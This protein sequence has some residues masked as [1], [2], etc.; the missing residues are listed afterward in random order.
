MIKIG[1]LGASDPNAGELLRILVNH[2]DVSIDSLYEPR[3]AGVPVTT[4]HHGLIA[5]LDDT[6]TEQIKLGKLDLVI[7][8]TVSDL[9]DK[10]VSSP[11]LY[12]NL[13]VIDMTGHYYSH[14]SSEMELGIGE[15][16]RKPLV[17]GAKRA[18]IPQVQ[19]VMAMIALYPF[20]ASLMLNAPLTLTVSGHTDF[21]AL[22]SAAATAAFLAGVQNSFTSDVQFAKVDRTVGVSGRGMKLSF[23]LPPLM[24]IDEARGMYEGIYDDHNFTYTVD[25]PVDVKEVEG[26]QKCL[27]YIT[28]DDAR[29]LHVD[30]VADAIL[31]GGAGDAVH[32]MNLLFGLHERT[33]L[34]LKAV[35]F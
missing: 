35:N 2:P 30:V 8:F 4:V 10:I 15:V 31:R 7:I 11:E 18:Y 16:N 14:P 32:V 34:A 19:V 33:G 6:F 5:E 17:R 28:Q 9:A 27:I 21:D 20:A 3:C 13:R 1:I 22:E 12:P 25:H 29:N 26:T 23:V 24:T